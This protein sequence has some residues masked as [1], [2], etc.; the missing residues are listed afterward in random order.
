M[1]DAEWFKQ[2]TGI[3]I[4]YEKLVH[5]SEKVSVCHIEGK[6]DIDKA[7]KVALEGWKK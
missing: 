1:T 5:F 7:R 2:E 3:E 4:T 6:L